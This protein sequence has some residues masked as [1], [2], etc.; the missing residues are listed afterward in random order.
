M[1][2]RSANTSKTS[3]I[4]VNKETT[5]RLERRDWKKSC[6]NCGEV[7]H[8]STTCDNKNK[9]AKY[10]RCNEFGHK[11]FDCKNEKPKKLKKDTKDDS[12]KSEP[13]SSLRALKDMYKTIEIKD[14]KFN[15]LLD[16]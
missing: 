6:F 3:N 5:K 16:S 9:G 12:K 8:N 2:P 13:V 4:N 14:K 1:K 10:F 7:G 15:A 11:S